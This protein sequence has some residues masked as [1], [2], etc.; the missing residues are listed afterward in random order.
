[1]NDKIAPK[2]HPTRWQLFRDVLGFQFKL[3][4]DGLR[5]VLLSPISIGAALVGVFSSKDNPGKY[6]YRLLNMG[7]QS[8]QWINLF[9]TRDDEE[10]LTADIF[11]KRAESIVLEELEKGRVVTNLKTRADRVI[12]KIQM[13]GD[14]KR[15]PPEK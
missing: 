5:D 3:A 14:E 15:K 7:H 8:D 4:I 6:F 12:D 1:M 11:V 10:R 9:N 2:E 13:S